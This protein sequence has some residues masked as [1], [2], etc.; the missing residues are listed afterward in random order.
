MLSVTSRTLLEKSRA[1]E[2][3]CLILR[4]HNKH[5]GLFPLIKTSCLPTGNKKGN[6]G[7]IVMSEQCDALWV[8]S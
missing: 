2:D 4:M 8:V 6:E 5:G 1:N 7:R 3:V